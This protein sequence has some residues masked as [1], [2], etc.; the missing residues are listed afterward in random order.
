MLM[1]QSWGTIEVNDWHNLFE[2]FC[3]LCA[4][5]TRIFVVYVAESEST[6]DYFIL[7][8]LCWLYWSWCMQKVLARWTKGVKNRDDMC[9][10]DA[11]VLT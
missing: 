8:L 6:H 11:N 10:G 7:I 9:K 5:H 1:I 3:S 2:I 4:W